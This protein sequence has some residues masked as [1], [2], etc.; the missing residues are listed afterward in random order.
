M[1]S[2]LENIITAG[3]KNWHTIPLFTWLLAWIGIWYFIYRSKF[4]NTKKLKRAILKS[5]IQV[6]NK[7]VSLSNYEGKTELND[8]QKNAIQLWYKMIKDKETELNICTYTNRRMMTKSDVT[9]VISSNP[10]AQILVARASDKTFYYEVW[11]SNSIISEMFNSFDKEQKLR[12]QKRL[13]AIR[14]TVSE[15]VMSIED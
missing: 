6:R 12:F 2:G 9:C 1:T 13:D 7:Y 8:I 10:D 5:I 15:S 4:G 14:N 11:L 3:N